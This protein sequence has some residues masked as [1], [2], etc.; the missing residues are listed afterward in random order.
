MYKSFLLYQQLVKRRPALGSRKTK[1][2]L[3][4]LVEWHLQQSSEYIW[5]ILCPKL[6]NRRSPLQHL[7]FFFPILQKC[8]NQSVSLQIPPLPKI[9]VENKGGGV[10]VVIHSDCKKKWKSQNKHKN[11]KKLFPKKKLSN[12]SPPSKNHKKWMRMWASIWQLRVVWRG[13]RSHEMSPSWYFYDRSSLNRKILL[14]LPLS[15][16]W[17]TEK[18]NTYFLFDWCFQFSSGLYFM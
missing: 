18:K 15:P 10:S 16:Q 6:P 12:G 13:E 3:T 11:G 9:L 1:S 8:Q 4:A 5:I 14:P 7:K 17:H 2:F